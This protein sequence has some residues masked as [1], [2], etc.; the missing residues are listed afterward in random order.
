[1]RSLSL[2]PGHRQLAFLLL[3]ISA[4]A[5]LALWHWGESPYLHYIHHAHLPAICSA[6]GALFDGTVFVAGWAVMTVAMML[7]TSTPL[8][9]I[10]ST[11]ARSRR[12]W[13]GLVS[14]VV[15]GYLVTWIA[16]GILAYGGALLLSE[17][18]AQSAWL[19]KNDW[20]LNAAILLGAGA[21][22]FSSLKYRCL[23]KC[24]SPFT[25]VMEHWTGTDHARQSLW[26]GVHHGLFC[27]GCCWTL[28]MLMLLI[29]AGNLGWMLLF[30]ILMAIEK[31]VS[32]GRQFSKPLGIV[33]LMSG[34]LLLLSR[35]TISI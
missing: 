15:A 4:L 13:P 5:W 7:P 9:G 21:Y 34:A 19:I 35:M 23:D 3:S 31:N 17:G 12:D 30:G 29:G 6:H 2:G 20:I 27:I 33:L 18:L 10:F 1:L 32:W 22:Q 8:I 26:L 28:M 11:V 25:F 16:A 14:L 24:R